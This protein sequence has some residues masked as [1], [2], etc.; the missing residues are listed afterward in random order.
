MVGYFMTLHQKLLST[1]IK[2]HAY[3]TEWNGKNWEGSIHRLLKV[4]YHKI[5]L[6]G[7][8]KNMKNLSQQSVPWLR[9]QL[10]SPKYQLDMLL[11]YTMSVLASTD[12]TITLA[13]RNIH[14]HAHCVEWLVKHKFNGNLVTTECIPSSVWI[15]AK[16]AYFKEIFQ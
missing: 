12:Y 13:D 5:H 9:L 8:R 10:A 16:K 11:L 2:S 7:L 6:K 3:K 4:L 15:L 1:A 14:F